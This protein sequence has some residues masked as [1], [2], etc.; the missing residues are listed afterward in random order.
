MIDANESLLRIHKSIQDI[1]KGDSQGIEHKTTNNLF[2]GTSE[3]LLKMIKGK[4]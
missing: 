4:Q 2:V 3:E 1:N